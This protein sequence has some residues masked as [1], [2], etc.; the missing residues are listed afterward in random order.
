[1][2]SF[3]SARTRVDSPPGMESSESHPL[4]K[5]LKS[6]A[7]VCSSPGQPGLPIECLREGDKIVRLKV[8]CACGEVIEIDCLYDVGVS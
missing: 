1:M 3:L 4:G 6:R 7:S 8:T 2:K 5:G